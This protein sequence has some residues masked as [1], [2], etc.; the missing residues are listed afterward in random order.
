MRVFVSCGRIGLGSGV[1]W[2]VNAHFSLRGSIGFCGAAACG[3]RAGIVFASRLKPRY[4]KRLCR[5]RCLHD[6]NTFPTLACS[7]VFVSSDAFIAFFA[8][9]RLLLLAHGCHQTSEGKTSRQKQNPFSQMTTII[10]C[11][12]CR[13]TIVFNRIWV[14][15]TL[16]EKEKYV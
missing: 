10:I 6:C 12:T 11:K 14:Y 2:A 8:L 16:A 5:F 4:F 3:G 15:N 1:F 7:I 9:L 13:K